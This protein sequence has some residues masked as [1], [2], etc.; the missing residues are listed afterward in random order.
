MDRFPGI[1]IADERRSAAFSTNS[2]RFSAA[3]RDHIEMTI[4]DYLAEATRVARSDS[5]LNALDDEWEECSAKDV[6]RELLI[7][8]DQD[9]KQR[10]TNK[11]S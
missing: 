5:G 3:L 4:D 11:P 6:L 1:S 2:E 8:W 10:D 7:E 9:S